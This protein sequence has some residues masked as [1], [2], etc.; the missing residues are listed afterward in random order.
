MD[1][2]AE[3]ETV[4]SRLR[5]E[6]KEAPISV[7]APQK[8]SHRVLADGYVRQTAEEPLVM[9]EKYRH[10]TVRAIVR[11]TIIITVVTLLVIAVI[12]AGIISI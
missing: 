12:K 11:W 9:T 5:Q 4:I 8:P 10:R 2:S 7:Q 3:R 6:M 1:M